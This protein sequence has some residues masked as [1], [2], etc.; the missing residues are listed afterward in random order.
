M[1]GVSAWVMTLHVPASF[2]IAAFTLDVEA[3]AHNLGGR[4][5]PLPLTELG[6]YG[7]A[8]L[9]GVVDGERWRVVV[10]GDEPPARPVVRS[11][12]ARS[13]ASAARLAIVLDDAGNSLDPLR[14][15]ER[16]P[17]EVAVAVLPN[18]PHGTQVAMALAAQGR[19]VLVHLP[20][21]PLPGH[22]PGPGPGAVETGLSD[23]EV[24]RR[25]REALA[26]IPGARGVNNHMGSLATTDGALMG[27]VMDV[28]KRERL[29]FLDSRTTPATVAE[30]VGRQ[31]GVATL[32]RD[33]FLDVVGEPGAVRRALAE[34]VSRAR[35]N[36]SAVA[37][38][39]VTA[40][41][42]EVLS[43]DL[44]AGLDGV[45]LVPPSHLLPVAP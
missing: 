26:A 43:A 14:A 25:V 8:R 44:A 39:H 33:V 16:L 2:P 32:R 19:E 40:V 28:L 34:A 36:G 22:G 12:S 13:R 5:D 38:G 1:E 45:E 17:R 21:E 23:D 24:R 31:V 6:G 30:V 29:Y 9:E 3:A 37:I 11:R 35:R 27:I 4:L 18:A 7:L 42:L 20:M 15:L 41:T 10:L